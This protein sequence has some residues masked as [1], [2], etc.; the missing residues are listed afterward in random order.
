MFHVSLLA[1][2]YSRLLRLLPGIEDVIFFVGRCS[3]RVAGEGPWKRTQ[4]GMPAG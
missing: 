3:G 4:S 1:F 2:R